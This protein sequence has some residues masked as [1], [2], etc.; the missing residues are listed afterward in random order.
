MYIDICI[1]R[2]GKNIRTS[3]FSMPIMGC[4][5]NAINHINH[6][7]KSTLFG[8]FGLGRCGKFRNHPPLNGI[9]MVGVKVC[10]R[11]DFLVGGLVAIY[12]WGH[13]FGF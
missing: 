13:T 10:L 7:L 3:V 5:A 1:Y 8:F 11:Y 12:Q 4:Q 6:P 2:T 9:Q